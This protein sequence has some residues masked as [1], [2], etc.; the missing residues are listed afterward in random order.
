[1]KPV[2]I[3]AIAFVILFVPITTFAETESFTVAARNY[4]DYQIFMNNGDEISFAMVVNGGSNDDIYFTLYSPTGSKLIDGVVYDYFSDNF[5]AINSGTYTF[6]FDNT[7]SII[8]NKGVEFSYEVQTNTYYVYVNPLPSLN[9]YAGDAVFDSTEAWKDANPNLNFYKAD[10]PQDANL[11]IQWVKEFG[12]E[13]VGYA[14][15]SHF[16][17]VGLGDSNCTGDWQPFSANHINWIM[18]HEIGHVLGL[19]HSSDPSSIMYPTAP[20]AQYGLIEQQV[21]MTEGY[22]QFVPFCNSKTI[23]DF[24]YNVNSDDPTYGFDVYVVPSVNEFHKAVDGNSFSHYSSSECFGE[25][26]LEY[27]GTCK[28]LSQGSGLL[29]VL[30]NRQTSGLTT[31]TIKQQEASISSTSLQ[32]TKTAT[33]SYDYPTVYEENQQ[34][35]EDIFSQLQDEQIN[36]E[37]EKKILEDKL[38]KILEE[39]ETPAPKTSKPELEMIC[40]DFTFGKYTDLEDYSLLS[41]LAFQGLTESNLDTS[42]ILVE[43]EGNTL[44]DFECQ[45][46]YKKWK[47]VT[48]EAERWNNSCSHLGKFPNADKIREMYNFF[49]VCRFADLDQLADPAPTQKNEIVCGS[50]TIEKNGQ[51]VPDTKSKGGGCLIATATYGSEL[52]PQVQQLRELRDNSLLNTESG[53]AF[54]ESFNNFYYSFSPIIA[55]YERENPIFREAVKIAIT[56]MITS[57]SILNYVEM[58]SEAKVL[59]YGVFL[60]LLN[61]GMYFVTPIAIFLRIRKLI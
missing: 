51:C 17:E 18:K 29:V 42:E 52:A 30:D 36:A 54:M 59:G 46:F 23:T 27:S 44:Y 33:I 2:I 1:M 9:H 48:A 49:P 8:S 19:E 40:E 37:N 41:E 25:G 28:G 55:D 24:S 7:G 14:Y 61:I 3:I 12:V 35:L 11:K 16:I 26:Y 6:R 13:H 34:A 60:I 39:K 10:T 56:L 58:D 20:S 38:A 4:Y 57:L 43:Y 21:T 45:T 5:P 15:G 32:F 31:L 22:V 53:S 50:G 47:Q